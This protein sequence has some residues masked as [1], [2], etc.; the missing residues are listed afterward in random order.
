MEYLQA[1][2]KISCSLELLDVARDLLADAAG[3]AGF[4]SFEETDDGIAGYV[5]PAI[6]DKQSLD[7]AIEAFPLEETSISYEI[8]E[9]E[10]KDWNET[11]E[12]NGFEPISV[13]KS[14]AV[15][16]GEETASTALT[17]QSVTIKPASAASVEADDSSSLVVNIDPRLA[18]GTGT[19][20]TTRMILATLMTLRLQGKRVL[21]CGCG[22]GILGITAS[23]MGAAEVLGYDIDEWSVE[24]T[25]HN[26]ALNSVGNIKAIKGDATVLAT[27]DGLFDIV[28]AN[29]NRN[30]LLQDMPAMRDKMSAKALL[31]LSGFY[32][33]DLEMLK[34]KAATLGLRLLG[35]RTESE[36]CC[37]VFS[38]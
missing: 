26:A 21:D 29:I 34:E 12:Q 9:A 25:V 28:L 1:K 16:M 14:C 27:V 13:D 36:W 33:A 15:P 3:E 24:N 31:I 8:V 7:E 37:A 30:I 19:H 32:N 5:Q 38:K 20:E 4:E 17:L 10:N 23:K 35:S 22:T 18:F 2:F 6:F 11:W